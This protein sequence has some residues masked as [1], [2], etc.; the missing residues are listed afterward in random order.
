[1]V[2]EALQPVR[3]QVLIATKFGWDI[4]PDS[5]THYGGLNSKPD[6]IHAAV[7]GV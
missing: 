2:G 6:H 4:D 1:M 3:D 7:E 5:A